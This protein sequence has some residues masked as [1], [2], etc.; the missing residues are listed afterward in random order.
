MSTV[1]LQVLFLS[2]FL[3]LKL[4]ENNCQSL[5]SVLIPLPRVSNSLF[6]RPFDKSFFFLKP[7][8]NKSAWYL[9]PS[10][11]SVYEQGKTAIHTLVLPANGNTIFEPKVY[12]PHRACFTLYAFLRLVTWCWCSIGHYCW[13]Q[14][15]VHD[16]W[17][18]AVCGCY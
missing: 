2:L 9:I 6:L 11:K 18:L 5:H 8:C 4:S 16:N 14:K 17:L 7:F 3:K 1:H 15:V 12:V 10:L 13:G